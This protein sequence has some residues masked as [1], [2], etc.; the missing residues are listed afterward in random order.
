MVTSIL[1][2]LVLLIV[3]GGYAALQITRSQ[4]YV[5]SD[6]QQ[7]IIYRGIDQSVAGFHLSSIFQR[8]GIPLSHV[9]GTPL[10][11]PTTA[12]TLAEAQHTV[13]NIRRTYTCKQAGIAVAELGEEQAQAVTEPVD[14]QEDQQVVQDHQDQ[15]QR[16]KPTSKPS[17]G[18]QQEAVPAQAHG[19]VLLRRPGVR[20]MQR[21]WRVSGM[22]DVTSSRA[23]FE[24]PAVPDGAVPMP[25]NR[26]RTELL[27]LVFAVVVVGFAYAATGLGL[28]GKVPPS[29]LTYIAGFAVIML[30]AHLAV[31]RLAPWADPL[32][33]PLAAMLN[34]LGV[35]MIWRL[36]EAGRN[37]NAG[38]GRPISTL[39]TSSATTQLI[40]SALGMAAFI[41]V[42]AFIKQPRVLQRYTYTLGAVGLVLLAIPALLPTSLSS[43]QGAKVWIIARRVRDPARRVRQAGPGRVL[44]RLPGRQARRAG[45]GRAA[46]TR[47][48]PAPGPRPG[49]GADRLG[50]QPAHPG[51]RDRHR[52]LGRVLRPV[53]RR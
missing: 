52:H 41:L 8:T 33:L 53:R 16:S 23:T 30:I 45:T 6:G 29:L 13:L 28:N 22:S 31:R 49:P 38:A 11:L 10:Q 24:A 1:V 35:V 4:Y 36:Q 40:W 32:M 26:R 20:V 2:V 46:G 15:P 44:R 5:D 19:P 50:R 3:G 18:A 17:S 27:M 47:H 39:T 25:R 9:Q 42:L 14:E 7:V 37:G 21:G 12:G 43:V 48:R 34:G 51:L